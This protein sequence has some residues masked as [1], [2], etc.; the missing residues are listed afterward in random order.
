[1]LFSIAVV[2][3]ECKYE[4]KLLWGGPTKQRQGNIYLQ[5]K[6]IQ[7]IFFCANVIIDIGLPFTDE[8]Y[9]FQTTWTVCVRKRLQCAQEI[10]NIYNAFLYGREWFKLV[11][12]FKYFHVNY[13]LSKNK[14]TERGR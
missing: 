1:M 10:F 6:S 12:C 9:L 13:F 3:A 2:E 7:N 5:V 4:K 8:D 14:N 11:I